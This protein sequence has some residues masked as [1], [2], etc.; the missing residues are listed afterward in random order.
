MEEKIKKIEAAIDQVMEE[1]HSSAETPS[2]HAIETIPS[3]GALPAAPI[4]GEVGD[5]H[6]IKNAGFL[7]T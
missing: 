2:R 3:I 5:I 1:L 6:G 4:V 7:V